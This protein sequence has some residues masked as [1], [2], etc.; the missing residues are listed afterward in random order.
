MAAV[1]LESL[2]VPRF[3]SG[4]I[5]AS[6][7]AGAARSPAFA[8]VGCRGIGVVSEFSGLRVSR[9]CQRVTSAV[10][11]ASRRLA[12]RRG[13]VV[14]EAQDTAVE[15][16]DVMK[17]TWKSLVVECDK[18][19]LVE[20]WAPW[21]GPCKLILPVIGKLSK[22]YEGKLECYKLN[23]DENPD[24]ATQY[25]I[26]SIPTIMIFKNGEK[27]D[28]VIGAVPESTLITSIEKFV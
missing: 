13:S 8:A 7:A 14:C 15:V 20:F 24:I 1:V 18:P 9:R 19:V 28:A 16:R 21:C 5:S 3:S 27:K 11:P 23:T 26:R 6:S 25:G 4:S 10:G 12:G 17:D 22:T 2:S